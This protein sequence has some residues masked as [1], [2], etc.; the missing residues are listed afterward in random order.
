MKKGFRTTLAVI[1]TSSIAVLVGCSSVPA[2]SAPVEAAS[3]SQGFDR[4]FI[5]QQDAIAENR[6]IYAFGAKAAAERRAEA[7]R[8][9]EAE[10]VAAA[11]KAEADRIA[12]NTRNIH[13]ELTGG[14]TE[15]DWCIGPVLFKYASY[16][17]VVEHDRCGGWERFGSITTGMKVNLSGVI[18][19]SYTVGEIITI[20]QINKLDDMRFQKRPVVYLQ[21]CIPGTT[22]SVVIGLY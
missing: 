16:T 14:Q 10:K 3:V 2:L 18:N 9:A 17:M 7:A 12:A 19:G 13:V 1:A 20:P 4:A 21:T 11:A 5:S 22:R 15:T 8:V 6:A